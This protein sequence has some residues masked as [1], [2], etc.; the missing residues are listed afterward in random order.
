M[1]V[2]GIRN[3]GAVYPATFTYRAILAIALSTL[4]ACSSARPTLA[5]IEAPPPVSVQSA[6]QVVGIASWYGP[7]FDGRRTSTGA[8]YHQEDLTA[9]SNEFP[10]GSR[11]M[12]TNLDNGRSIEVAVIDRGPFKKGRKID[13]SHKAAHIIGMLD[14]GTAPVRISLISAPPGAPAVGAPLRYFVQVG[15]F[16]R[17]DNAER[18]RNRLT[19]SYRD[20]RV[21]RLE[22][23]QR[24]YYRV[25]MGAFATRAEAES[26][27]RDS[28]HFGLPIIIVPE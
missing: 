20:V 26:R 6:P 3:R 11:V 16:S 4:V 28:A 7:G 13:L 5:P 27:A 23:D 9:A 15:S 12:V 8:I 21:D 22:A 17:E 1:P 25:R 2:H 14:K 19:A 10:L 18:L 24:H